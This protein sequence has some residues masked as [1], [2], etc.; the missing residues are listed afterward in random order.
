MLQ[1]FR[2][3]MRYVIQTRQGRGL[4]TIFYRYIIVNLHCG[5]DEFR[6]VMVY[7]L[8]KGICRQLIRHCFGCD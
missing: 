1:K 8:V 3:R 7:D 6:I 5:S 4:F 2:A